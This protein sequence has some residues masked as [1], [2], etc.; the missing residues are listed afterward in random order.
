MQYIL[1]IDQGGTKTAAIIMNSEGT[2][3]G[4]GLSKGAYHTDD[5]IEYA[6]ICVLEA[7]KI[8]VSVAKIE[9]SKIT[10]L[11]AGMTGMDWP[12][13][14]D[15]LKSALKETI[16]IENIEVYNDCII[17]MYGGTTKECGAVL[18]AGTGLNAAVKR[19]SQ[20]V[21]ILGFYIE[22]DAQG[23]SA[24]DRKSVV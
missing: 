15:L 22:D 18:C 13:E 3:L 9:L 2:I 17:A 1:G 16:G 19:S 4:M 5:G 10:I 14:S 11:V 7:V 20:D 12:H 23:G 24:L 8:A 21:F 6:M